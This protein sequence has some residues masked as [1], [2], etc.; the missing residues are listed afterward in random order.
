MALEIHEGQ[1]VLKYSTGESSTQV[2]P[3]LPGGVSDGGWHTV[4]IHYYNKPKRSVSGE[5]QGP[6]DEKIA[7]VS[8]DDCDTS[9]SL[10]F[11]TQLGNYS[12]A[13]QGRQ[14]SNK[15][16]L[17]L[18]GP[19]FLG[20][21]PNVPDNFPFGPREFI[22]CMKELH[23]DNKPLD[24]AGFIA[25]NGTLP[26][27]SAKLPFCKSNPCQNGGT[28]SVSWETFSCDC[29]LG[30][31]GKDC[32]HAMPHPHRFLGNSVL[33]WDLKND[34]TISAPWYLGLVFRT[35][36]REGTLL[37]AQAGQYTSLLFQVINGQLVFSVTRGGTKP[38]QLRLDQVQVADGRWHDLQLELRDV[39]SGRETRYVATLRLDF[40]LFQGTVIVGND[41][42]GL[43]VKHLHV[44]GVFGSGEVQ[45]GIRGCIQGVR[46]G[47]RPDAPPLPRPSKAVKVETG[48][49]VGNPCVSSPCPAHS[50]CSDQWERHT[51]ICEPGKWM[52]DIQPTA[53]SEGL[54]TPTP[55]P[56]PP[57]NVTLDFDS[58]VF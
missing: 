29:P 25:N 36:A 43:K 6:S 52:M 17:D 12:C 31:G 24:L 8:V 50:R 48:C 53:A 41:I 26:G 13:A 19:L 3:Y 4:H 10:R 1:V 28:C 49:T 11:G 57:K 16:S 47:V 35:R 34:V 51:C 20:G 33:W 2:S 38:V 30:F 39:R 54:T 40:G 46:L 21:V 23:I 9:L 27:C 37:Q 55:P 44:G 15:K 5:A 14:T 32:S 56:C 22:G 45:N 42:H 58:F 18:T 7:V